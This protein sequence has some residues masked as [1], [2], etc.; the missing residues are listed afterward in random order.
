M[1]NFIKIF[2]LLLCVCIVS[3]DDDSKDN[4]GPGLAIVSRDTNITAAGGTVTVNLSMEGDEAVSDQTWCTA[5][6]SGKVVTVILETNLSIE[7]RTAMVTVTKGE[8][9]VSFPVTQPSNKVPVPE[10]ETVSFD[11]DVATKIIAVDHFAP[12]EAQ[13]ESGVTWLDAKVVGSYVELTTTQNN[14]TTNTLSTTVKLIS[15]TLESSILVTQNGIVLIPEK[16]EQLLSNEGD[17]ITI[18]VNSTRAFTAVS[19]EEWLTVTSDGSSVTLIAGDNTGNPVRNATVTLTSESLTAT[20]N[21]VQRPPVYTDYLGNWTL[22]GLD[23]GVP[24]TYNLSIGQATANSTYRVTGWGK[25]VVATNSQYAIQAKFDEATGYIFITAQK[26]L[27]TYTDANGVEFYVRFYG[28]T[29]SG[30]KVY[31]VPGNSYICYAGMLHSDG[32]VHWENGLVNY[33]DGSSEVVV[34]AK[35][36]IER[37]SDGGVLAFNVDSPFMRM[38][39]MT[40]EVTRLLKSSMIQVGNISATQ[41]ETNKLVK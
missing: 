22:T 33:V 40:K 13:V 11:A 35:Y 21:V 28:Q 38:P 12:F 9:K 4:A 27:G 18:K 8:D 29:E 16:T 14:F 17:E 15:G 25:S 24:F 20:I 30:G 39:V 41:V 7:G 34:G 2:A 23:A 19:S 26:D 6:V 31:Y 32:T 5:T 3:C 10:M 37:K 36:F 1:K